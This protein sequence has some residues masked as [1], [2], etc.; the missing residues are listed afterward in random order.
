MTTIKGLFAA[1]DASGASSHKFSSGSCTEGRI[2][3]KAMVKYCVENPDAPS[4]DAAKIEELKKW[5][6]QPLDTYEQH[7]GAS[8]DPEV[9]PHYLK[10]QQAMFRLQKIM[11]EYAGGV[12]TNFTTNEQLLNK[13]LELLTWL[14]ED[15]T[16]LAAKDLHE[17]LRCWENYHRTWQA[18]SHIRTI[19]F[20]DETRWPGYYFRSDRPEMK[21]DWATFANCVYHAD[22]DEWEMMKR[23][24]HHIVPVQGDHEL[25]GG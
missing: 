23:P 4:F 22:K 3:A 9:N 16:K 20:R 25:V 15:M 17:L 7:K 24:I 8:T 11:D 12:S 21:D 14:K 1:G 13:G 18:E 19:L 10:P 5:I 2:A 6:L